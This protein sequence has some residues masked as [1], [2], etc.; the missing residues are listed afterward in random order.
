MYMYLEHHV[1]K[2]IVGEHLSFSTFMLK[3][4]SELPN[5]MGHGFFSPS[6]KGGLVFLQEGV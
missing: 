5:N 3:V 6:G 4:V 2:D 1:M